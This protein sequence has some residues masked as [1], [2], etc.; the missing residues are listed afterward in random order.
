MRLTVCASKEFDVEKYDSKFVVKS[1]SV[2]FSD[3]M[4]KLYGPIIYAG[5]W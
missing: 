2:F 3:R 4:A 1:L 5:D